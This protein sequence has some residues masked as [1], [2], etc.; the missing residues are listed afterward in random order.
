MVGSIS[1][2]EANNISLLEE[3]PSTRRSKRHEYSAWMVNEPGGNQI[4]IAAID[5]TGHIVQQPLGV[6]KFEFPLDVFGDTFCYSTD[7]EGFCVYHKKWTLIGEGA[8]LQAAIEDLRATILEVRQQLTESK[9]EELD[10]SA[11]EFRDYLMSCL[12][13]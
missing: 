1:S 12:T 6:I 13:I 8:T 7:A 11:V 5:G 3:K 9:L 4:W 10:R 2:G